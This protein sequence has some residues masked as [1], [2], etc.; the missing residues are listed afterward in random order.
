MV[1]W[2][3]PR[4]SALLPAGASRSP[5]VPD[6]QSIRMLGTKL[7]TILLE[8]PVAV[9]EGA[10][11]SGLEPSGDAVEVE[12]VIADPPCYCALLACSGCLVGLAFNAEVHN[13]VSADGA[14][15]DH[16][17]PCP[18]GDGIPLLDLELLLALDSLSIS[19]GSSSLALL[20]GGP[21]GG[22]GVGHVDV[23]HGGGW[24]EETWACVGVW[25]MV[26]LVVWVICYEQPALVGAMRYR[27]GWFLS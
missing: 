13:V 26:M 1:R 20:R 21:G 12:G 23:S 24:F 15:I 16:D 25:R 2:R 22:R 18:K 11:L 6:H 10:D 17:I 8:F 14:V 4:L 3:D 19:S 5:S 9:V 7:T 27:S